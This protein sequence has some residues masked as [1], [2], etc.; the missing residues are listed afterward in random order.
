MAWPRSVLSGFIFPGAQRGR[1]FPN[2]ANEICQVASLNTALAPFNGAL[3]PRFYAST[4]IVRAT[5]DEI[6]EAYGFAESVDLSAMQ[7]AQNWM[8]LLGRSTR[9]WQI[10][11][12]LP[13]C[14]LK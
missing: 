10:F 5:H 3:P 1:F 2:S 13:Y 8:P 14:L 4:Q 12:I 7:I 6:A 11:Q 9:F